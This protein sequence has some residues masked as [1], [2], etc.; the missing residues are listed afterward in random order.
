MI[1]EIDDTHRL[2][3]GRPFLADIEQIR[4]RPIHHELT[5]H[6]QQP[7]R[8]AIFAEQCREAYNS[9]KTMLIHQARHTIDGKRRY[10]LP[11]MKDTATVWAHNF[12]LHQIF[13]VRRSNDNMSTWPHNPG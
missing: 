9:F 2:C 6:Q 5:G 8:K 11:S 3:S 7:E 1:N 12:A 13:I 10:M 4:E